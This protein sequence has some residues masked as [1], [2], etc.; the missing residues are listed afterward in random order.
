M[1]VDACVG[2]MCDMKAH[3]VGSQ[4]KTCKI[5]NSWYLSYSIENSYK[6]YIGLVPRLSLGAFAAPG[7][8]SAEPPSWRKRALGQRDRY[9]VPGAQVHTQ[10]K[11]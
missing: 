8:Q 5:F 7:S 1:N 11:R 10:M 3:N 2:V 9:A 6:S 4:K